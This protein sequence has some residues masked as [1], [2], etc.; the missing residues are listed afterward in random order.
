ML[1][2]ERRQQILAELRRRGSAHLR[3]LADAANVSVMTVR[4]DIDALAAEG[5]VAR[6]RGGVLLNPDA[7]PALAPALADSAEKDAVAREAARL[8]EPGSVVGIA[9]GSTTGLLARELRGV[10]G[11]TVVT[12]SLQIADLLEAPPP[13]GGDL[14]DQS[15]VLTGGLRTPAG[16][17]VGPVA[18]RALEQLHC[19]LVFLSGNGLAPATGLTTPNLLEAETNRAL[20]ASG[21]RTVVVVDH[22]KWGQVSLATIV[23]IDAVDTVV[24][25][26]GLDPG[27][28]AEL[29]SHV[30]DVRVAPVG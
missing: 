14:P 24:V 4:R 30:P 2:A 22:T 25:D 9:A 27:S 15:V 5:L 8:V 26:A 1:V 10:P 18:V 16:A 6:T 12:N 13:R 19:D 21:R 7:R 11:L 29:R 20:V 28:L 17:L 23:D 3:D